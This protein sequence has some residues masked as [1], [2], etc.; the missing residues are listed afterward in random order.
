MNTRKR[1]LP[2]TVFQ[3]ERLRKL[4]A[5]LNNWKK[6]ND[7]DLAFTLT[8]KT[9]LPRHIALKVFEEYWKIADKKIVGNRRKR[10]NSGFDRMVFLEQ[11]LPITSDGKNDWGMW[12]LHGTMKTPNHLKRWQFKT[13]L[14]I[15]LSKCQCLDS[16]YLVEIY[17]EIGE[18][19]YGKKQ[20]SEGL[21]N[22]DVFE[23][24][25]PMSF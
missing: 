1:N 18:N 20:L 15:A 25:L 13:I 2:F 11:G 19:R 5:S 8:L 7:H 14:K 12:H 24:F 23:S 6:L 9:D 16:I 22:F 4:K 10:F 21:D 17:D 3:T